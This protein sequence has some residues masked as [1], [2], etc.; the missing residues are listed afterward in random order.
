MAS[1]SE[2][3][4]RD[5]V[6][7][8]RCLLEEFNA[9]VAKAD[10]AGFSTGAFARAAL[11]GNSGPRAQRRPPADHKTLRQLLGQIGRISNNSNQTARVLNSVQNASLP[12]AKR[13]LLLLDDINKALLDIRSAILDALGKKHDPEP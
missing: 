4:Q 10:Q 9:I 12:E 7:R 11:L 2:K 3:R 5:K 6:L 8:I 1:G 13:A